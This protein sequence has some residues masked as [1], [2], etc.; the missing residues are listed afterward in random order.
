MLLVFLFD[1]FVEYQYINYR[2]EWIDDGKPRG[3]YFSPKGSSYLSMMIIGFKMPFKKGE[4]DW[5][6]GDLVAKKKHRRLITV[7]KV[8]LWYCLLIFPVGIFNAST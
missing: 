2:N 4:P 3:Y 1:D 7:N 5:V 8:W 6:L